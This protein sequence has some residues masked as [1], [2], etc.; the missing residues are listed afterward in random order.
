MQKTD[1]EWRKQLTPGQ[2][3]ILREH[4][5]ERPFS[6]TYDKFKKQ[7]KGTYHC[8]GCGAELFSSRE[9]F[10]AHCGWP[11][12]FDASKHENLK[13]IK[14]TSFGMVRVEVRCKKCNGHLGHIFEGEGFKT[15][16]DQRYC[17]NGAVLKFVPDKPEAKS[18][19]KEKAKKKQ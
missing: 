10:D 4:G 11:A 8:A 3:K 13:T 12:F 9:K 5:T 16:T 2:Y 18:A 1:E 17:I 7:G 19:A 6:D 15:P 14:D